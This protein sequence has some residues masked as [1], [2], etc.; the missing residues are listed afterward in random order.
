MDHFTYCG[1]AAFH[2]EVINIIKKKNKISVLTNSC[3]KY[4]GLSISQNK[5]GIKISQSEYWIPSTKRQA[6]IKFLSF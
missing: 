1:T 3:F 2:A 6:L 4:L 5:I